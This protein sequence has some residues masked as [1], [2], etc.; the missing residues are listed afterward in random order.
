[1]DPETVKRGLRIDYLSARSDNSSKHMDGIA[2]LL[3]KFHRPPMMIKELAQE[4]ANYIQR[5]FRLRWVMIGL[6]GPDNFFRYEVQAGMKAEAWES[7]KGR[8][9]KKQDFAL[10][11]PGTYSAGEI[12]KLTR[13]YLEEDNPLAEQDT[14]VLNRPFLLHSKRKS[15][16]STLEA[17]FLDTLVL[18]PGGDLLGWIEYSGTVTNEFPDPLAIRWIE[19]ISSVLSAAIMTQPARPRF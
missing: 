19:L 16:S 12:S 9:Y 3:A 2:S 15:R 8:T 5:Q 1:M 14:K 13:I 4:I 10:S 11:V 18:D 7:Q 6:K 17:D